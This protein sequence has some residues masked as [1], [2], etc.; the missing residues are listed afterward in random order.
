MTYGP[1]EY[2]D[3]N[4]RISE[5]IDEAGTAI[6]VHRGMGLGGI[7][8]NTSRA[9]RAATACGAD[10]V[11]I[12][13]VASTDGEWYVF[14]DG[15]ERQW[16]GIDERLTELTAAQIDALVYPN[17]CGQGVE[18]L[19]TLIEDNPDTLLNIDRSWRYWPSLL[20][21][22]DA[23]AAPE[24]TLLKSGYDLDA[25]AAL[26]AHEV[27]Y[28]VM[29]IAKSPEQIDRVQA[30]HGLNL[31]GAELIVPDAGHV[32]ADTGF[33]AA[34]AD[35][36]L[37][38]Y[39]NALDLGNG[40]PMSAGWDDTAA[41]LRSPDEGWGELVT[42]GYDVIQTDWPLLLRGYLDSDVARARAARAVPVTTE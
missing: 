25:L 34:L 23:N 39:V 18:R 22:L 38:T 8:E 6:A 9:V 19:A 27:P 40:V 11:E 29:L 14:H 30:I 42:R 1:G 15:Y 7:I 13:I 41:V 12:D 17:S 26:A 20:R 36:G 4:A 21:W 2:A 37:F 28:P 24:T 16:F 10:L 35:R 33:V 3:V 32:F 5:R 31:V